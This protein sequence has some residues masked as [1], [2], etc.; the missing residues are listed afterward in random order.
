MS[1]FDLWL[2]FVAIPAIGELAAIFAA[3][4]A[5]GVFICFIAKMESM[6]WREDISVPIY[7]L[8]FAFLAS[9]AICVFTPNKESMALIVGGSYTTQIDG[10]GKLPPNIVNALN[11]ALEDYAK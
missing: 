4:A 1:A 8:L 5:L 9:L 2:L 10:M 11:K 7:P 6:D 3:I